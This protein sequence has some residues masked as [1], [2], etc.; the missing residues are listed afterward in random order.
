MAFFSG[1]TLLARGTVNCE[2]VESAVEL[3]GEQGHSFHIVAR[4]GDP[5]CFVDIVCLRHLSQLYRASLDVPLHDSDDWESI[6][7][8]HIHTL[9][10]WCKQIS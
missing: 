4:Y 5:S 2:S 7:C 8:A 10:F 3:E 6:D 9:A 1:D